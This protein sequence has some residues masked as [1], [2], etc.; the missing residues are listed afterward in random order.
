VVLISA[1]SR[2]ATC[3]HGARTG[4]MDPDA[5]PRLRTP[6]PTS[7]TTG[8]ATSPT[9]RPP[10]TASPSSPPSGEPGARAGVGSGRL[11]LPLADEASRWSAS[12]QPRDARAARGQARWRAG[13]GPPRRH[14]RPPTSW[15]MA[16][17]SGA[18]RL[19][20]PVQPDRRGASSDASAAAARLLRPAG[21]MLVET[22]VWGDP[23]DRVER[24]LSTTSRVELD[25]VVLSAT[26]HD[27]S[28]PRS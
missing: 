3:R 25:R 20:H 26:E 22:A 10:S 28:S 13:R 6:S 4:R 5:R 17:R 14:G 2:E 11:A 8:T 27:P 16:L 23:P 18:H 7:T 12:T 1:C 9:S 21:S 24:G 15:S 19:Q